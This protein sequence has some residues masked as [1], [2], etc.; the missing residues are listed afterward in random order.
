[1]LA[2]VCILGILYTT[3]FKNEYNPVEMAIVQV[4]AAPSGS[5]GSTP[6]PKTGTLNSVQAV[7][8]H[9]DDVFQE[10]NRLTQEALKEQQELLKKP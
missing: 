9:A 10:Q 6:G 2:A 7:V 4:Q 1:M 3:V 5:P 8:N